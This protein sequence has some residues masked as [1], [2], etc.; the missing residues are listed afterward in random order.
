MAKPRGVAKS[1]CFL[2]STVR[3]LLLHAPDS[4]CAGKNKNGKVNKSNDKMGQDE[5]RFGNH[6]IL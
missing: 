5:I 2:P 4:S 6:F 1:G 3:N